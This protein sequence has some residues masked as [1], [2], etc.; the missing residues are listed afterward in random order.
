MKKN[1][2]ILRVIAMMLVA[3][4]MLSAF[5]AC[6]DT[7]AGNDTTGA[8]QANT[9]APAEEITADPTKDS[10]GYLKDDLPDRCHP[11]RLGRR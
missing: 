6:A 2:T 8:D 10:N 7:G 4:M 1:S 5:V 3:M 9:V 11:S